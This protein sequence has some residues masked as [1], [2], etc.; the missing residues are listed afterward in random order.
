[1]VQFTNLAHLDVSGNAVTFESLSLLPRLE[2]LEMALNGLNWVDPRAGFQTLSILDLSFNKI[3]PDAILNLGRLPNLTSLDL[4]N[5]DLREL[6]LSMAAS[7]VATFENLETLTLND[8]FLTSPGVFQAL[9]GLPSLLMLDLNSNKIEFVPH[10]VPSAAQT[11][12]YDVHAVRPFQ[13]LQLLGLAK[14]LGAAW[15]DLSCL[16][17]GRLAEALSSAEHPSAPR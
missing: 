14:E 11:E 1:M 8:N 17:Q 9:A 15:Q 6:P 4:S 3:Q 2:V 7:E 13:A 16:I 5:N 12:A 10:L